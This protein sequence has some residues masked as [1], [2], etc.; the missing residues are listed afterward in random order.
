[1]KDLGSGEQKRVPLDAI[2]E[3]VRAA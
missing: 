3:A 2:A 1:V